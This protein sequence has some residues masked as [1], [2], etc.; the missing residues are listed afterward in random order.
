MKGSVLHTIMQLEGL[1][2]ARALDMKQE[3]AQ[4]ISLYILW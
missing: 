3:Q 4:A 1:I 2:A